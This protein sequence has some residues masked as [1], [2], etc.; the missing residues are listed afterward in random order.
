MMKNGWVLTEVGERTGS[1]WCGRKDGVCLMSDWCGRK[2]GV[3]LMSD[4]CGRKDGVCLMSDVEERTGSAWCLTDVGE[5]TG[6]AWCLT[7]VGE[8]T[9]S[10]WYGRMDGVWLMWENGWGQAYVGDRLGIARESEYREL[11]GQCLTISWC[12][13]PVLELMGNGGKS[14]SQTAWQPWHKSFVPLDWSP[15]TNSRVVRWPLAWCG[16]VWCGVVW[17]GALCC[18][19]NCPRYTRCS[20]LNSCRLHRKVDWTDASALTCPTSR[21]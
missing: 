1:D 11:N 16:V 2:D 19:T 7:D 5:R 21:R 3:C 13:V 14:R 6:S 12:P 20:T 10:D 4:W 18:G 9:G 8:R 17:C 15:F